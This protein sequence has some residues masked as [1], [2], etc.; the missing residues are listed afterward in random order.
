M[1]GLKTELSMF[2]CKPSEAFF[3]LGF[4][5]LVQEPIKHITCVKPEILKI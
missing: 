3:G 1:E 5:A 2:L 4:E